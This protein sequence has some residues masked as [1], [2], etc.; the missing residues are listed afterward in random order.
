[1][2]GFILGSGREGATLSFFYH[3]FSRGGVGAF[4]GPVE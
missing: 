2:R 4:F 3:F 1:M